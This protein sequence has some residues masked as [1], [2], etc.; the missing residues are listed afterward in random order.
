M[1]RQKN[2]M[3]IGLRIGIRNRTAKTEW[4]NYKAIS[5]IG[6]YR[7]KI[8]KGIKLYIEAIIRKRNGI[9]IGL[10]IEI[11]IRNKNRKSDEAK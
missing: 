2:R 4:K 9:G 5:S 8:K 10:K 6:L 7:I 11:R 1:I 3:G